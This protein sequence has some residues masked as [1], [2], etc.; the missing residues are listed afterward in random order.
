MKFYI[1]KNLLLKKYVYTS[2]LKS[3]NKPNIKILYMIV[4]ILFKLFYHIYIL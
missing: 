2:S 3:V 1:V 4:M